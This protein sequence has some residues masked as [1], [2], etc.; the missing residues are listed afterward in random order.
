MFEANQDIKVSKVTG[1]ATNYDF[2]PNVAM[3]SSVAGGGATRSVSYR[4]SPPSAARHGG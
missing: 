2:K 4:S 1:Q 3:V